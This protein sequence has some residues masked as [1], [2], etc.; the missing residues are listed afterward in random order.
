MYQLYKIMYE[1]VTITLDEHN[2]KIVLVGRGF[3]PFD[4]VMA[5]ERYARLPAFGK[6][7]NF[8]KELYTYPNKREVEFINRY[9]LIYSNWR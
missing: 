2:G 9:Y 5:S 7:R 6:T 3:T 8:Q 4:C 1:N